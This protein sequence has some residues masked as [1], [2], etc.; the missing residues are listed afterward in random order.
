MG[1]T[2]W[3]KAIPIA[4][5][6]PAKVCQMVRNRDIRRIHN[7]DF[8]CARSMGQLN[9]IIEFMEPLVLFRIVIFHMK[10]AFRTRGLPSIL[11]L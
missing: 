3:R 6:F 7:A 4:S 10:S 11:L 2:T 8:T 5:G 9:E 1:R